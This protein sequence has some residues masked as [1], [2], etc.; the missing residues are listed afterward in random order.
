MWYFILGF[1]SAFFV[2][3]L[4]IIIFWKT[5]SWSEEYR[6]FKINNKFI[7]NQIIK[8]RAEEDLKKT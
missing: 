1:I 4:L 5:D 8:N 6:N 2:Q 3:W 7:N